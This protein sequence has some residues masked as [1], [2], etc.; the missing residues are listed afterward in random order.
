MISLEKIG[1]FTAE[2]GAEISAYDPDTQELFVVDGS[3]QVQILDLSDPSSPTLLSTVDVSEFLPGVGGVNSVA[4]G[5]GRVAIAIAADPPTDPG[6][7]GIIDIA[8][9]RVNSTDPDAFRVVQ[10][11]SLPDM[12]TFTPDSARVLSANEGE[13]A[14]G[15]DPIGLERAGEADREVQAQ[16]LNDLVDNIVHADPDAKV[17][18]LGDFNTFEFTNDLSAILPGMGDQ[19]VLTNL[20]EQAVANDEA[21]TFIFDGNS[22]VL[23]HLFVTDAL[24]DSAQLD[25]VHINNDFTQDDDRV[26]FS[27]TIAASD[28]EPIQLSLNSY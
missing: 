3:T 28:H 22:Q 23:D 6:F 17:I 9:F 12:V 5:N 27:D 19:K 21:C 7:V 24:L 26:L 18:V 20:V 8:A 1:S 16:A 4:V 10:V 15:V 11:G 25:I 13:P 14:D 2:V